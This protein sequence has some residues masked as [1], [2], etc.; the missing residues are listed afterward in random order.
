MK[1]VEFQRENWRDTSKTL[2]KIADQ[3]DSGELPVCSIGVLAMRSPE[4]QVEVF[5]FGPVADDLQA[6]ALFR[7]AEQKL[8]DV[9]LDPGP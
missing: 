2:R 8:I 3:L 7:L 4:G 6:L 1:V 9:L 5:G